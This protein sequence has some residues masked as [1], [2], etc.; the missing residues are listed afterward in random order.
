[1]SRSGGFRHV[2]GHADVQRRGYPGVKESARLSVALASQLVNCEHAT[3][4][5]NAAEP[6]A[7]AVRDNGSVRNLLGLRATLV[8][9]E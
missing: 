5:V 1:M 2:G 8:Q 7:A 3:A 9:A 6:G 4:V